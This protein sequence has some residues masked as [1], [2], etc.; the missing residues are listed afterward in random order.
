MLISTKAT[1]QLKD[2]V[3]REVCNAVTATMGPDGR[4]VILDDSGIPHPTK[5]GVSVARGM[6]FDNPEKD[7]ISHMIAECC[8]RTD[9]KCGDGTTTTA[10]LLNAFYEQFKDRINFQTKR[11]LNQY[12][13]DCLDVLKQMAAANPLNIDS[14]LLYDVMMT[15]SNNDPVIVDKVLEIY[16]AHPH[17]PDLELRES[18]DDQD[19]YHAKSGCSYP[20]GFASPAFSNL[21]NGLLET[22]RG[23]GDYRILVLSGRLD[24]LDNQAAI[25]QF[26]MHTQDYVNQGGTYVIL[27]RSVDE[28]TENTLNAM[29][30]R[31]NRKAYKVVTIRAAG[32]AGVS[33]MN[34]ISLLLNTQMVSELL[35]DHPEYRVERKDLP[36][37]HMNA[38]MFTVA[39]YTPEHKEWLGAAIDNVKHTLKELD[40]EQRASALGRIVRSR[41]NILVGSS[42]T[43][44]VGGLSASDIKERKDRFEDVGRV[45]KAALTNGVLEGCGYTLAQV[46]KVLEVKYPDC[47]I[48]KDFGRVLRSQ[49]A[50]LMKCDYSDDMIYTNLATGETGKRPGELNIWDAAL[51]TQTA[52]EAA[53]GMAILLMDTDSVVLNSNFSAPRF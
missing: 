49:S 25:E 33:L 14:S 26:V 30:S 36:V 2:E 35:Q 44:Y 47:E 15:T 10:F 4:V 37:I 29:N 34:D 52:L 39:G 53:V 13:K 42:V 24:G 48:A 20:G 12:T 50:Y 9:D 32:S 7:L 31:A 21:G 3:V 16:R 18:D 23:D 11:L 40:V 6:R 1:R 8:I 43:V 17:L 28:M 45:C 27:C 41:L 22:Y 38:S 46:S 5:D 51:A 19:K